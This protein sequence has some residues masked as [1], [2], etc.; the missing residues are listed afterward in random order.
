MLI[1]V[2]DRLA[3][4]ELEDQ[5][6]GC[7]ALMLGIEIDVSS[8]L[9]Q[10]EIPGYFGVM[11]MAT[12]RRK[13][14]DGRTGGSDR[15]SIWKLA[16]SGLLRLFWRS[17]TP[18]TRS[19]TSGAVLVAVF[20]LETLLKIVALGCDEFWRGED[21]PWNIFDFC[22]VSISV[23]ESMV[24]LVAQSISAAGGSGSFRAMR[25]LRLA[26][27][28]RGVRIIRVFRYF[29]A[30]R[31]LILSIFSTLG[32]LLWTLL[33]LLIVFYVFSCIFAQLVTDHCRFQTV[34]RTGDD[35]AAPVCPEN[36]HYWDNIMDSM[37]TLF[38]AITGGINWEDAYIPLREPWRGPQLGGQ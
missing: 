2:N 9:G 31:G 36:L 5:E 15:I 20:V 19:K 30:L 6:S 4:S 11:N 13:L 22:I 16:T 3:G 33:L 1:M 21:A 32:S 26:R 10:N 34:D 12:Q 18:D 17:K 27:T 29:S 35:N 23:V 28:L 8:T 14:E 37:M 38:M 7:N 25:A 24:D